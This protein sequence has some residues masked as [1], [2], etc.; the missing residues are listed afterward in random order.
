MLGKLTLGNLILCNFT[1]DNLTN[2][3]TWVS[4]DNMLGNFTLALCNLAFLISCWV[5]LHWVISY[6]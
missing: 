1:H 6:W 5:S 2:K 4:I 3:Q